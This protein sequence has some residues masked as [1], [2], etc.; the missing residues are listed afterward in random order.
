MGGTRLPGPI[1]SGSRWL[2]PDAM[3]VL[4]AEL[5]LRQVPASA[6]R[7]RQCHTNEC[8]RATEAGGEKLR[9]RIANQNNEG[10]SQGTSAW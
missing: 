8:D 6:Q 3:L 1:Q 2:S 5:V 9:I 7:I 10:Y 4:R